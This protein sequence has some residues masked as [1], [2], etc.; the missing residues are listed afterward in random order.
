[1][2]LQITGRLVKTLPVEQ[3]TSKAGKTYTKGGFAIET[4]DEYPKKILFDLM[5]DRVAIIQPFPIGSTIT[6][7]FSIE[8]RETSTG[9]WFTSCRA[10]S[11]MPAQQPTYAAAGYM[12]QA[13]GYQPM[14]QSMQQPPQ[15][16]QQAPQQPVQ[17]GMPIPPKGDLPF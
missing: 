8:S 11:V 1:M 12:P 10:I 6:V 13:Q 14:P 17:P 7:N 16:Y 3:G 4:N 15:Q 2:L 5:G 9:K